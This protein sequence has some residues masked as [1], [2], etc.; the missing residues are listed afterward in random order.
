MTAT[1]PEPGGRPARAYEDVWRE[2]TPHVL[3]ALLRRYGDLE[4]AED[5]V[6]EALLAAARQWP[7]D[8]APD[9]P[10]AWLVRVASRRLVDAWRSDSARATR[11]DT[12]A[13]QQP[14]SPATDRDDS[15]ALLLLC[16]H[17]ALSRPSQVA[18][19][20]R[21]V[22]GLS[23]D[24][25]ARA[26]LVPEATMAQRLARARARLREVEAPFAVPPPAELPARVAAVAHVLYVIF[27]EGH[28]AT[29]GAALVDVSLADEAIR[30]TRRLHRL[31]PR[32]MAWES[33][34]AGLLALMLLTQAR[35][36]ART[37]DSGALVLLAEQDRTR[38]DPALVAEGIALVET[39]LPDGPV[40]PY[41]LQAAIAAVHA[42]A[43]EAADTDWV[44]IE[45]LY[46]MLAD[47]AP[48]PVVTLN[49]AVAI[50]ETA[51]PEAALALVEPLLDEPALRRQ[52]RVHAVHGH[53]LE[54]LG[55]AEESRA[56][57]AVAA[58]LAT[59]VPEQR[60]LQARADAD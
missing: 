48:S 50:A 53:L 38:W 36:D 44:Q 11:E 28:T 52:H 3:A 23:T 13:R 21:A 39:A 55:R 47:L 41:Q 57:Y 60:Y 43:A 30:L 26:F 15:L 35:R 49:R 8:G 22:G 29:T 51:G 34:V 59:S 27:T 5:A 58:R 56:A 6:Q 46:G 18:L 45:I 25:I 42:E 10:R 40:G 54:R 33:E 19:T 14:D 20:L 1:T 9:S 31:L 12:V 17:P 16:C 37:D 2:E 7:V 24:R 32:Q 4:T